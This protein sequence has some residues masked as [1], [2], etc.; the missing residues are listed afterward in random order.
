MFSNNFGATVPLTTHLVAIRDGWD[1]GMGTTF[2]SKAMKRIV[3]GLGAALL[4]LGV[5]T[6]VEAV[7]TT[8]TSSG[9][10]CTIVGTSGNNTLN[11]TA[12]KDAQNCVTPTARRRKL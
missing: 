2:G 3:I 6:A 1:L 10:I 9:V 7:T 11:G 4:S 12:K 8:K 5:A